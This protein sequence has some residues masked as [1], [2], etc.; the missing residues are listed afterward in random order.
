MIPLQIAHISDP[1]V[2]TYGDS[3]HKRKELIKRSK[4]PVEIAGDNQVVFEQEGWVLW[5]KEPKNTKGEISYRLVDEAGYEHMIPRSAT[6]VDDA[7][8]YVTQLMKRSAKQLSQR[9]PDSDE[10]ISL[11]KQ[12]PSNTNLRFIFAARQ[13]LAQHPDIILITGDLTDNGDGYELIEAVFCTQIAQGRL[14]VVP[15]NH[16]LYSFPLS[17]SFRPM[18][19]KASKRQ[20]YGEFAKKLGISIGKEGGWMRHYPQHSTIIVGLDSCITGQPKLVL[21]G[22]QIGPLQLSFLEQVAQT[23]DWQSSTHRLVAFHHHLFPVSTG[24]IPKRLFEIGMRLNDAGIVAKTLK[25][26]GANFVL[27]GHRHISEHRQ[28]ARCNFQLLSAP[29]ITLGCLS[30]DAP[31][32]WNIKLTESSSFIRRIYISPLALN[33]NR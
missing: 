27:H 29:S 31:S 21:H 15:G 14:L 24:F 12:T 25:D 32:F 10:L 28:P 18:P 19:T 3:F 9:L 13:V 20:R 16:D 22:G 7:R 33:V 30:G 8:R 23:Q 1:H 5:K 4:F 17:N 11:L 26:I 6:F 2:S